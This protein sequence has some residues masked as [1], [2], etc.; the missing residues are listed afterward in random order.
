[1]YGD[2]SPALVFQLSLELY[3]LRKKW[4]DIANRTLKLHLY[5]DGGDIHAGFAIYDILLECQSFFELIIIV[6]GVCCSAGTIIMLAA[7]KR[8]MTKHSYLLIH[9]LSSNL[10]GAKFHE[11]ED[12]MVNL[13][14]LTAT[15]TNIYKDRTVLRGKVLKNLL[16]N[17]IMFN[18]KESL[19]LGF[20]HGI[21]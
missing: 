4:K 18:A 9:N 16:S 13:S 21:F 10:W 5:T 15:L 12:E 14:E 17:E 11:F 20:I 6:E 7:D 19:K 3:G 1:M 8:Y 2:I